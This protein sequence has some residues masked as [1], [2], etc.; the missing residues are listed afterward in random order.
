MHVGRRPEIDVAE[1][2]AQAP[3]VLVFEIRAVAPAEVLNREQVL[4]R[5]KVLRDV[6]LD[7]SP[8]ILAEAHLLAV[9]PKVEEGVDPV[10][11]QEDTVAC[12]IPGHRELAAIGIDRVVRVIL[13]HQRRIRFHPVPRPGI[14]DVDI[15][16][17]AV[18]GKLDVRRHRDASPAPVIE[19]GAP[20][21]RNAPGVVGRVMV[22]PIAIER[23]VERRFDA[24]AVGNEPDAPGRPGIRTRDHR[25]VGRL[26]AE[27]GELGV[28][29]VFQLFAAG[30]NQ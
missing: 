9:D 6:E 12:P 26:I 10:E 19:I 24:L 22:F 7:G 16:G 4:T 25:G 8:A 29:P 14:L 18:A 2:A 30:A 27:A 21:I 28:L 23:P 1:Y 20:E 5:P 13:R 15:D 3:H 17:D 11:G